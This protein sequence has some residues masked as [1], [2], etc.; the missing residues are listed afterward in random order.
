MNAKSLLKNL[1]L[2]SGY[3]NNQSFFISQYYYKIVKV[4]ARIIHKI[5]SVLSNL[6]KQPTIPTDTASKL[7]RKF[8]ISKVLTNLPFFLAKVKQCKHFMENTTIKHISPTIRY[9]YSHSL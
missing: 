9:P 8:H 6:F 7:F 5:A 4:E 1:N 3:K 2:E